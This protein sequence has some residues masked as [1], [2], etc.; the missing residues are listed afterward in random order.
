[1]TETLT[2]DQDAFMRL[3]TENHLQVEGP[4]GGY[5]YTGK[6]GKDGWETFRTPNNPWYLYQARRVATQANAAGGAILIDLATAP[7]QIAKLLHA[8][9]VNSGNNGLQAYIY[10]ED[11]AAEAYLLVIGAAAGTSASLPSIG[12]AATAS[13]NNANTKDLMFGPGQKLSFLQTAA[14]AQND[15]LT[16][17]ITLLLT[18]ATEPSWSVARST[19]PGNVTL[20]A[21]TISAANAGPNLVAMP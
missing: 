15:T 13:A 7:G 4:T 3:V 16:L 11:N 9:V 21:N 2:L 17:G 10:D 5:L 14:G 8:R 18:T 20:A 19:N 12:S 1:M 6:Q